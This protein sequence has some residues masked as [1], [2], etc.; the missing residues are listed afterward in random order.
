MAV[1]GRPVHDRGLGGHGYGVGLRCQGA[2][3]KCD[4]EAREE[5]DATPEMCVL[6]ATAHAQEPDVEAAVCPV[7]KSRSISLVLMNFVF[8][9][10]RARQTVVRMQS[11]QD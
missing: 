5:E 7:L 9:S 1:R 6:A 3:R 11:R 4:G 8:C 10:P 2:D